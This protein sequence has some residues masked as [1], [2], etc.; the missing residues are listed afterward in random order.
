MDICGR[1][2]L[3]FFCSSLDFGRKTDVMTFE[4]PAFFLRSENISS[5]AGM[6]LNCALIFQIPKHA[7]V[8]QCPAGASIYAKCWGE[9]IQWREDLFLQVG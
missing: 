2:D 5:P 3:F 1:G 9:A 4:E 8:G 6:A 7:L